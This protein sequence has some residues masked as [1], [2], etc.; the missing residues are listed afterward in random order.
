[1]LR[2]SYNLREEICLSMAGILIKAHYSVEKR[3]ITHTDYKCEK[4][5]STAQ[6]VAGDEPTDDE[7]VLAW[8]NRH[9]TC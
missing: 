8:L 7:R 1:M 6:S 3:D 4:C 5:H 9:I 2:W